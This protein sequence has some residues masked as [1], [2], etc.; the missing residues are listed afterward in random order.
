MFKF[1]L[2]R[3]KLCSTWLISLQIIILEYMLKQL[4]SFNVSSLIIPDTQHFN[5]TK[6]NVRMVYGTRSAVRGPCCSQ[7][8]GEEPAVSPPEL[9]LSPRRRVKRNLPP[10]LHCNYW[11]FSLAFT[12]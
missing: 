9:S 1:I 10:S 7:R 12:F 6:G 2:N 8:A 4:N 3:I 11:A 5:Y